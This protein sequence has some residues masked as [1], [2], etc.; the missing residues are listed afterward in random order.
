M[1][2]FSYGV[3]VVGMFTGPANASSGAVKVKTPA[4]LVFAGISIPFSVHICV[5]PAGSVAISTGVTASFLVLLTS[6]VFVNVS[7]GLISP[8][9]IGFPL[10][11]VPLRV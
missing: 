1:F 7:P 3:R 4:T 2:H 11:A 9:L 8:Q 5:Q 6:N 10:K